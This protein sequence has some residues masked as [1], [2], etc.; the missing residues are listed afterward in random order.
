MAVSHE[1]YF[2]Y[3]NRLASFLNAQ[4]AGKKRASNASSRAPKALHW[5]HKALQPE[6]LA[7]AGFFFD[8][9][10]ASPD[11]ATCFLCGK[12]LDGWEE[13]DSPLVEHVKHS[14]TCGWAIMAAI[15]AGLGGYRKV[16][17]L[18]PSMI[19]ARK[20]TFGG[21]WPYES[22]KGFK[23]KT[24][25]LAEAGWNY[26]PTHES[27]DMATCAYCHLALD[28]WEAGDKPF[29]EHY[30][31]AADCEFFRLISQY[32]PMKKARGKAARASN[33]SVATVATDLVSLA[34][35][36]ADHDDSVITTMTTASVMTQGG[37]KKTT[38]AKKA[39]AAK[40]RKTKAK[41]DEPV[42]ILEDEP[43]EVE[44]LAPPP[45][46][47]TRGRK[48]A[49]DAMDDLGATNSEAPVP[50]KRAT[51]VKG[52][53]VMDTSSMTT[54]SQDTEMTD[55]PAPKKSA[56][57]KKGRASTAKTS[58]KASQSSLRSQASTASLRAE[59]AIDDDEEIER[60]LQADLERPLTDDECLAADSD[61]ERQQAQP[62]ARG[63]PKKA[64]TVRQASDQSQPVSAAYAMFDPTPSE[65]NKAEID[66]EFEKLEAEVEAEQPQPEES[67][68]VPKKGRKAG[69]RKAS[70]QT[71]KAKEPLPPSDPVDEPPKPMK[72]TPVP[73]PVFGLA[74]PA[75]AEPAV[76][77]NPEPADDPDATTGTVMT[78]PVKRGRGRPSKKSLQEAA[79][80]EQRRSSGVPVQIEVQLGLTSM[81]ESFSTFKSTTSPKVTKKSV[82]SPAAAAAPAATTPPAM[83]VGQA[84][85]AVV[86]PARAV[87]KALPAPPTQQSASRLPRPPTTPRAA[88]ATPSANAKQATISPSQSPQ[89]SDAENQPPSSKPSANSVAV[90]KRVVL[91]P[92]GAT[93][94]VPA[95]AGSSPVK[96]NVVAGLQS[97]TLWTAVDLDAVFSPP[98][99]DDADK[100]NGV[101]KLLRKGS[102]LTS[103]EKGMT[104]EE[105]IYHNAEI[106]EQKL[107]Y[108]CEAMVS[109]FEREAN[110]A[111]NVLE[112]LVVD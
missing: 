19:D 23:C 21:K 104:V 47:P 78:Q 67:L 18:E 74:Q 20:A 4:P 25:Q 91:A 70:K 53:N 109:T 3:E 35:M 43:Q 6:D 69:T 41:K 88:R 72:I 24:K 65:P 61:S 64:A 32:P 11:N 107:K 98:R 10:P 105:W 87:E 81:R 44:V 90:P 110:R 15:E 34:D 39:P 66:A 40:G 84:P 76:Y 97:T 46:K 45:P 38:R 14:P 36:T 71:K 29:D 86:T 108:E 89:S 59:A 49:S 42:E 102:E 55:V 99:A 101:D 7:S 13:D 12:G 58:R 93:T 16:H 56:A 82:P 62:V 80:A 2:I 52:N 1:Q 27:D 92:V 50:K 95:G 63:R 75:K 85:P 31:R 37:G 30:K 73:V 8:P 112:G 48:R 28:G 103:P 100:E 17:P 68:V 60:Q 77:A 79:E 83:A 9:S 57:Q 5:P 111:M 54:A 22:K 26:T 33:Q 106:A 96:R 94:P 51:R